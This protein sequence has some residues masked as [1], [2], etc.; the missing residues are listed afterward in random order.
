MRAATVPA[1]DRAGHADQ[2]VVIHDVSWAG[3]EAFLELKGEAPVPRVVYI[4]TAS[5]GSTVSR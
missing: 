1:N 2:R 5:T 3:F 4:A